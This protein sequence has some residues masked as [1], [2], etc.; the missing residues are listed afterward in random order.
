[1]PVGASFASTGPC[2]LAWL[3][4]HRL[5]SCRQ[6]TFVVGIIVNH[7]LAEWACRCRQWRALQVPATINSQGYG[8]S[9]AKYVNR[10]RTTS[11]RRFRLG[12]LPQAKRFFQGKLLNVRI[13]RG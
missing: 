13:F 11:N 12:V 6:L 4:Q 1:M 5:D 2:A 8:S 10:P 3:L 9:K 7:L